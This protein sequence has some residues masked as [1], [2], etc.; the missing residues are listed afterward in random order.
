MDKVYRTVVREHGG[1]WHALPFSGSSAALCG[2][3]PYNFN[4]KH[5]V[6]RQ[7]YSWGSV[8]EPPPGLKVTC[9]ACLSKGWECAT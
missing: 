5:D 9:I 2:W 1:V 7:E 3:K 8:Y 4:K 6:A